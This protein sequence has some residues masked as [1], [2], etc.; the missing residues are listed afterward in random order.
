MLGSAESAPDRRRRPDAR[1]EAGL[2]FLSVFE[3]HIFG[4]A[5]NPINI[6]IGVLAAD[7]ALN[8]R[9]LTRNMS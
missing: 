7:Y 9:H 5:I 1:R 2:N 4:G 8:D 6:P 3:K